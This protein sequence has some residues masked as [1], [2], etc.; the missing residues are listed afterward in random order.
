MLVD[1]EVV[2]VRL[3]ENYPLILISSISLTVSV[4]SE[5]FYVLTV[6]RYP[7]VFS[8]RGG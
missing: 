4:V 6:P 3:Y 2:R 7:E 5:Q 8:G 1:S